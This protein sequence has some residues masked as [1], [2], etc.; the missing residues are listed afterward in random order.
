MFE[1]MISACC[2]VDRFFKIVEADVHVQPLTASMQT[3]DI[4]DSNDSDYED[5]EDDDDDNGIK[6]GLKSTSSKSLVKVENEHE[7]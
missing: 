1:Q 2:N 3:V 5:I 7:R 4:A 6:L